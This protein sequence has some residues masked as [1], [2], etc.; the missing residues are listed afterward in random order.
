MNY[1][2]K[3]IKSSLGISNTQLLLDLYRKIINPNSNKIDLKQKELM[4]NFYSTIIK[5]DDLC[6]D[7]GTNLGNRIDV[8]LELGAKVIA[9]EPQKGCVK[10]LKRKYK[11]KIITL[12]KAVGEKNEKKEFFIA[13]Y[14]STLSSLSK[15]WIDEVKKTRFKDVKW[16]KKEIIDVVSLDSLIKEFGIPDFIKIDV[17]GYELEV[18]KGLTKKINMLSFEYTLP[19]QKSKALKCLRLLQK[20]EPNYICN[21][22]F[23]E[24]MKYEMS[25]F[26]EIKEMIEYIEKDVI[27][28][29]SVGD[30]YVKIN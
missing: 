20:I 11:D 19:E 30:I 29:P 4:K 6:F 16:N 28:M 22:S 15:D 8:F 17:E 3:V 27:K 18:L 21:Y 7:I 1:L 13:K 24:D 26:V 5:K 14:S 2:K 25:E 10:Y 9:I 23:D 12:N